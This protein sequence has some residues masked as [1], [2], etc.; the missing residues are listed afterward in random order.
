MIAFIVKWF[1]VTL[2]ALG[3][4]AEI[5]PL[6]LAINSRPP[7]TGKGCQSDLRRKSDKRV[8][9]NLWRAKAAE[10]RARCCSV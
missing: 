3:T 10:F 5:K 6:I 8:R 4:L 7:V 2:Y 9:V 1:I